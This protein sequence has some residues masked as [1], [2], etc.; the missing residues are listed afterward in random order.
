MFYLFKSTVSVME[1]RNCAEACAIVRWVC[2]LAD[3][4]G[5]WV[6]KEDAS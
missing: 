4:P 6:V 2:G 3:M 1:E 5:G